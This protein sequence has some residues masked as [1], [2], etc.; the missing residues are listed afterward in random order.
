MCCETVI[1]PAGHKAHDRGAS[2]GVLMC[3]KPRPALIK[4]L[5]KST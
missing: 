3:A 1:V 2:D 5:L 4:S